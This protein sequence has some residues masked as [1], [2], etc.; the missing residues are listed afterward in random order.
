MMLKNTILEAL[1]LTQQL[2][3]ALELDDLDQCR[4]LLDLRAE[5]ML[6][7]ETAHRVANSQEQAICSSYLRELFEEDRLLQNTTRDKFTETQGAM[8]STLGT[9]SRAHSGSYYSEPQTACLD[10]K[11]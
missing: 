6:R 7:F 1:D 3:V 4:D 10:R 2:R 11:V 9:S 5:A 8:R